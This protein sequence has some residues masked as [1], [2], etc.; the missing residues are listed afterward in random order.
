M[1]DDR[2]LDAWLAEHLFNLPFT[3]PRGWWAHSD[4]YT[5]ECPEHHYSSTW[6]GLGLVV[7]AMRGKGF[8]CEVYCAPQRPTRK[9]CPPWQDPLPPYRAVVALDR[10]PWTRA[11]E[12]ANTA[13]RAVALAAYTAL[14]GR[15]WEDGK[16]E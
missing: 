16:G 3:G 10:E 5:R 12:Y 1:S 9:S 2:R 15:K 7:E 11:D 4:G 6:D 14:T 13:P 8:A